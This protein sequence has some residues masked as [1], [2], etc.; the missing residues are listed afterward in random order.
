MR[1]FS[2]Y[3]VSIVEYELNK[4]TDEYIKDNLFK[5]KIILN[6]KKNFR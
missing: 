3:D 6:L 4:F 1:F 2:C 5:I